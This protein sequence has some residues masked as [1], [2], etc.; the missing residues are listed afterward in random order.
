MSPI[1]PE[2][3]ENDNR[4][5]IYEAIDS[6]IEDGF[7]SVTKVAIVYPMH[8]RAKLSSNLAALDDFNTLWDNYG[9]LDEFLKVYENNGWDVEYTKRSYDCRGVEGSIDKIIFKV[10]K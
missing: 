6:K 4:P 8:I 3:L 7:S 1:K 9:L 5:A 10:K 2:E